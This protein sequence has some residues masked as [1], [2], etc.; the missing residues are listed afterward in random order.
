MGNKY[1]TSTAFLEALEEADV[2]YIFAN[3]GSDH[4]AMIEALA[5]AKKEGKKLPEVITTPHEFVAISAAQGYAQV[6]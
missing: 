3:L 6:T 1:T 2:S 4:P 5:T